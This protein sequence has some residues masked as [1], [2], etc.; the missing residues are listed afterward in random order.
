MSCRVILVV[1]G[2]LCLLGTLYDI[3]IRCKSSLSYT[4][5]TDFTSTSMLTDHDELNRDNDVPTFK[6]THTQ[7]VT[8]EKS[9]GT[10][11]TI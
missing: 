1:L 10:L 3:Y 7:Y 4:D 2:V 6:N 5:D 8:G 9:K 11:F